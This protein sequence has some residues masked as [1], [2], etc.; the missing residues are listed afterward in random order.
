MGYGC[1]A[2]F[3]G[4]VPDLPILGQSIRM[5]YVHVPMWF[6]M[7]VLFSL[8]CY[9]SV[10]YLQVGQERHDHAAYAYALVGLVMGLLGLLTGMLWAAHTW[11]AAWSQDPKQNASALGLLL[12]LAYFILRKGLGERSGVAS[13]AAVYNILGFGLLVPLVFVL[14][15]L[16]DS[17]HP[18]SGGNPGFNT[19][20]LNDAMRW[21]FYPAVVGW[22]G[23]GGYLAGILA[24]IRG[25]D[26]AL[27]RL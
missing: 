16:V 3:L 6:A 13:V 19:Y 8:S 21:V 7:V 20:D 23:I 27:K 24:A 26:A 1:F 5:L 9:H 11:G 4:E 22:I 2:G 17:L 15:R 12:Y 10:R 25:G 14:P 18:G